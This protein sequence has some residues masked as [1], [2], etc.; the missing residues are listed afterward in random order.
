[1]YVV[2]PPG[3]KIKNQEHKVYM[4]KKEL[5]GLK[6]APRAWYNQIDHYL[7]NNGFIRSDHEPTLYIKNDHQSNILILCLYV[8][9]I[10]YT[11]NMLLDEF[12]AT[13]KNEFEM[14]DLGLMRYF[15][16]IEVKQTQD[17]MFMSQQKYATDILKKFKMD[18][19]KPVDTPIEVGTKLSKMMWVLLLMRLCISNLLV[20]LCILLLLGL[21]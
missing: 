21:I 18:R 16:G 8:D 15:L 14:T 1:M 9:D 17:G 2:Q 7:L 3:F 19:C 12:K 5:Y 6:Q 10:I 13:M 11:G 4:L 20:V